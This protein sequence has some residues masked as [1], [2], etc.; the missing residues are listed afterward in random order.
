MV[1]TLKAVLADLLSSKKAVTTI[2]AVIAAVLL[3]LAARFNLGLDPT[4]AKEI[5]VT[6]L[7]GIAPYVLGQAHVDA[8]EAHA[9]AAVQVAAINNAAPPAPTPP[10]TS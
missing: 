7:A 1:E 9:D 4:T 8:A 3:Q 5:A 10:K 6:I 2:C